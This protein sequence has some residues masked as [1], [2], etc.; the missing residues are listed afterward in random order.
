MSILL[1]IARL[2]RLPPQ[3]K[4]HTILVRIGSL[5]YKVNA[6]LC[7]FLIMCGSILYDYLMLSLHFPGAIVYTPAALAGAEMAV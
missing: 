5:G 7:S 3:L 1:T 6:L 2:Y 4:Q